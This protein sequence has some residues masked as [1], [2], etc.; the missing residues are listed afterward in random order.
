MAETTAPAVASHGGWVAYEGRDAAVLA[1][2]LVVVAVVFAY[3]GTRLRSP[4]GVR[5]PGRM[6]GGFMLV[7]WALAIWTF[8]VALRVYVVQMKQTNL[9]FPAPKVN[10]G[11]FIDAAVTFFVILYLTRRRGWRVALASALI[12]PAAA[13]MLFEL[14][15]DL[16]VIGR[17]VPALP[18]D[19]W[20]YRQLFFLPLF[21]VELSTISLLTLLPSMRI[22]ARACYA[23]AAMFAVFAVWAAFGFAF[24]DEPLPRA[25]NVISKVL[26]FVAAIML[27]PQDA[28]RSAAG[29]VR[30]A[31]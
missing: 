3:L 19:P 22:T 16:I 23:L 25:L 1:I 26:C 30:V 28:G 7:I 9:L 29:P 4:V 20:L 14:P 18:P 11:T 2:V 6:A 31:K 8:L 12:G 24:P 10:V 13:P 27:F 15:F 21:M 5:S 17:T